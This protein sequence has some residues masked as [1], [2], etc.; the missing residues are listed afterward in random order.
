MKHDNVIKA[1]MVVGI[2]AVLATIG[3]VLSNASTSTINVDC[4]T[5]RPEDWIGRKVAVEGVAGLTTEHLFVLWN[6]CMDSSVVVKWTGEPPDCGACRV[7][8][9]GDVG[10]ETLFGKQRLYII[11][12]SWE[13]SG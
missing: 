6:G 5:D 2:V 11:A 10:T 7:T 4:L 8:V 1:V 12:E 3:V 13:L 9:E